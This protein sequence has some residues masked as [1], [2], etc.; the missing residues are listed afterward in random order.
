VISLCREFRAD[1]VIHFS[2]WGCRQSPGCVGLLK[3][4]LRREGIP[5]LNLEGDCVDPRVAALEQTRTRLGAF[6]EAL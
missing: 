4:E 1:G 6:L 5:L 2:H 3:S